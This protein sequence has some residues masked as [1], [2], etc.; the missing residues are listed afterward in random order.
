MRAGGTVIEAGAFVDMGPV[1]INPNSQMCIK[2][3]TIL[4][5]GGETLDQYGPPGHDDPAPRPAAVRARDHA[6]VG[7]EQ[8]EDAL[9]LAQTGRGDEGAGGPERSRV[10]SPVPAVGRSR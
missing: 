5:I 9:A 1:P 3:V 8:V 4:G 10:S 6:R 7:L 2:G